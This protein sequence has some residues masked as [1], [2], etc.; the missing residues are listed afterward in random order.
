[1]WSSGFNDDQTCTTGGTGFMVGG[2]FIG[3]TPIL[4]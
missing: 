1:M 3:G 4:G 2:H